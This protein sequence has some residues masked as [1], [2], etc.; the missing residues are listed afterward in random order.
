MVIDPATDTVT[1]RL[2][3]EG[4][5]P[6][7]ARLVPVHLVETT[8]G[9]IRLRCTLAEF[10]GLDHA[11]ER[12]LADEADEHIGDP[13]GLLGDGL[14]YGVA[15]DAYGP[16][17]GWRPGELI[18]IGSLPE[19]QR[20]TIIEDLEDSSSFG[21]DSGMLVG[22]ADGLSGDLAG[23]GAGAAGNVGGLGAE[24]ECRVVWSG[25]AAWAGRQTAAPT[26]YWTSAEHRAGPPG[27]HRAKRGEGSGATL[28]AWPPAPP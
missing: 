24:T 7:A 8:V 25:V 18:D 2:I 19:H 21:G 10:D 20:K 15:G 11:E 9:G 4:H 17:G 12:E 16:A 27:C 1:H 26:P 6:E 22:R 28:T 14:V 3:Q 13:G 5:R 23:A